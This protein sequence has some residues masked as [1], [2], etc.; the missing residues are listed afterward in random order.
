MK[1]L[2]SLEMASKASS[3]KSKSARVMFAKVSASFS[4]INGESPDNLKKDKNVI[5]TYCY[6][7]GW[8]CSCVPIQRRPIVETPSSGSSQCES[9]NKNLL[10]RLF[11]SY[12]LTYLG[13][14]VH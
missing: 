6:Y 10:F 12:L 7:L 13:T 2:A 1:C 14:Q 8:F 4:P 5:S 3:S 11:F 9:K